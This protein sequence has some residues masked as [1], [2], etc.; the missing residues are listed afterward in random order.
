MQEPETP[1]RGRPRIHVDTR[2]ASRA[3][4]A[5]YRDRQRARRDE[6]SNPDAPL[7]STIIDLSAIPPWRRK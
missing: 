3:S 4:S 6:L 2:S 7:S 1:R 5:A